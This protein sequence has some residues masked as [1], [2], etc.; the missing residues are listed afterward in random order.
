MV[1]IGAGLRISSH[2]EVDLI[3]SD[4]DCGHQPTMHLLF[5]IISNCHNLAVPE[6]IRCICKFLPEQFMPSTLGDKAY[7]SD[8]VFCT[9][10]YSGIIAEPLSFGKTGVG[11]NKK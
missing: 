10:V 2:K 5:T 7:A 8:V 9:L 11:K 4:G 6:G 3:T 1:R